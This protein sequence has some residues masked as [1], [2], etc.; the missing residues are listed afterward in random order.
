[1]TRSRPPPHSDLCEMS[2]RPIL[3]SD[4]NEIKDLFPQLLHI[5]CATSEPSRED[6]AHCIRC[7]RL[8]AHGSVA[9]GFGGH[10]RAE[11]AQGGPVVYP[12]PAREVL[13]AEIRSRKILIG[14]P[15]TVFQLPALRHDRMTPDAMQGLHGAAEFEEH[16]DEYSAARLV[17]AV[18]GGTHVRAAAAHGRMRH[19]QERSHH[20]IEPA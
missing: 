14:S 3:R 1:M 2:S 9:V 13:N 18:L 8:V 16:N 15:H 6:S 11:L 19:S 5:D 17:R 12:S 4:A 20:R 10:R 7:S